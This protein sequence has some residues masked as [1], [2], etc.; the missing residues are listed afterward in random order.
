MTRLGEYVLILFRH[1]VWKLNDNCFC[2][3][4]PLFVFFIIFRLG[5]Q[6]AGLTIAGKTCFENGFDEMVCTEDIAGLGVLDHPVCESCD[7]ARGLEDGGGGHDGG[8]ELEHVI[9]DDE[10]FSPLGHDVGLQGGAWGAIIIETGD[11]W[12]GCYM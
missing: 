10:V 2:L 5:G 7:V 8:V 4:L 1:L 6:A 11:A 3:F 9:L 12:S